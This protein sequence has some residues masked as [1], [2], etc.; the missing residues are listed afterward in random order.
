MRSWCAPSGATASPQRCAS[1]ASKARVYYPLPLH[2]QPCFARLDEPPLPVAE[3][4]CRTA[5]A[6]PIFPALRDE[7]QRHVI[8][9]AA[10]F[11]RGD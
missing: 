4:I 9:G 10:A 8:E 2:R 5:L 7:Q 1:A 3:E 11:F 6:L